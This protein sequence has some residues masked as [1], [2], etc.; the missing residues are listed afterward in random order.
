MP[1]P[2]E[3]VLRLVI[4]NRLLLKRAGFVVEMVLPVDG[5]EPQAGLDAQALPADL[6]RELECPQRVRGRI[7]LVPG[8]LAK[9]AAIQQHADQIGCIGRYLRR[10]GLDTLMGLGDLSLLVHDQ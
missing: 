2:S 1:S 7:H 4:P 9:V 10:G 3:V 5:R 6:L 8:A